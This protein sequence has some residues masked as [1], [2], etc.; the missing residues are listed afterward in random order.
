MREWGHEESLSGKLHH[1]WE[2]QYGARP[3]LGNGGGS[4]A[5]I[6]GWPL[7]TKDLGKGKPINKEAYDRRQDAAEYAGTKNTCYV[8][9][10]C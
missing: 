9:T 7:A 2:F 3:I 10:L 4:G 8:S 1:A 5:E 6:P